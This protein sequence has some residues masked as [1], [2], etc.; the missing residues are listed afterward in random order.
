MINPC[1]CRNEIE[2]EGGTAW[3][4]VCDVSDRETVA[5][6]AK[7]TRLITFILQ[8]CTC[9]VQKESLDYY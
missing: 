9:T 8:Y 7:E 3:N 1:C 5:K 4:I 6:A 2:S